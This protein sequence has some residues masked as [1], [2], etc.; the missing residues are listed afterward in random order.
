VAR[1]LITG[2]TTG[3]GRAAANELVSVGHAPI[4]H[5]RT[6]DRAGDLPSGAAVVIGDLSEADQVVD[7]ANQVD[8]LGHVDAV[9]HNAGI[10]T[11]TDRSPNSVQQPSI[12]AVNVYAPYVLT[13][14]ID[15][16]TRLIYLSS[17]MH[18]DGEPNLDDL[19]WTARRWNGTQAYCDSKLLVTTFA[20]AIARR[21]P[22]V[23]SNAVDPGWVPTR[24]GGASAPDDLVLGHRTQVQLAI[25]TADDT[26]QYWYH[27]QPRPPA[28]AATDVKFQEQLL[29]RLEAETGIALP[30]R[31]CAA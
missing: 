3:L 25:G 2:S 13:A 26:G 22:H 17:G 20:L 27:E 11:T 10:Y 16:P 14:L 7:I 29:A 24:M 15:G 28:R 12:L 21:W 31:G 1:V 6:E 18:L 23:R 8:L 9:I 5:A 4:F 30:Q 19:N